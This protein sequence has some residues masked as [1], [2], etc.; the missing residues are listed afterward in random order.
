[1]QISEFIEETNKI[2][3]FYEKELDKFQREIWFQQLKILSVERYRQ[4]IKQVF[5]KCKFMPKLA[6]IVS[7]SEEL[8][9]NTIKE[10]AIT[11]VECSKCNGSGLI[12]YKK[13]INNG[14]RKLEYEYAT[15]CDC[16]N[17]LNYA[18]DGSKINDKEHRSR[19]YIATAQQIGL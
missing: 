16:Q 9:Y 14:N 6:D 1:M 3:K 2:E 19:Y 10:D 12:F 17:G 4:I 13:Y 8:P 5:N 18:Y 7:I 11:K 15:R